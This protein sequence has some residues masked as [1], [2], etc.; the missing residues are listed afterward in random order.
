MKE[1]NRMTRAAKTRR[2][3][4]SDLSKASAGGLLLSTPFRHTSSKKM[5]T[6]GE[7]MDL[8]I[9]E[10]TGEPLPETVD[11]LKAGNRDTEVT[12]IITTMFATVPVI[13]YAIET[14]A[15]FIIPHEPTFYNHL[16]E[17]DW[18]EDDDT[19]QY[20]S[21]LLE[22]NGIA[23][24]RNHDYIHRHNPDGVYS[25][26][27]DKLMWKPYVKDDS[28]SR[29]IEIPEI[30]LSE[31]INHVKGRLGIDTVRYMGDPDQICRKVLLLP[32][33]MG[34]ENHIRLTSELNPDVLMIGEAQE[35]TTPEYIRDRSAS[36]KETSLIVLGHA[37]SEDPG[38]IYMKDWLLKNVPG[39]E[40][41]HVHSGNPFM[42]R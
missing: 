21:K 5:W 28:N 40:V 29:I 32:G 23:I 2:E 7:I 24:W 42:Y 19:F 15:N 22:D 36:G 10:A 26:I 25:G 27:L 20:K 11:T 13:E 17:T 3:F 41:M 18:L 39:V 6:V 1:N 34:G 8:F 38:S 30:R 16:D 9:K 37:D 35:W 12:G 4:I 33:A 14:G 31:L